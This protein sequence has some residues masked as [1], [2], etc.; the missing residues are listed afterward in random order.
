[1]LV[2]IFGEMVRSIA[3]LKR[4]MRSIFMSPSTYLLVGADRARLAADVGVGRIDDVDF[5]L[6]DA[7]DP[8]RLLVDVRAEPVVEHAITGADRRAAVLAG[9]PRQAEPRREA[10]EIVHVR[11]HFVAQ[12]G[13]ERQVRPQP[14]IV[15]H[16]DRRFEVRDR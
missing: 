7:V 16:V 15:L 9:R 12:P 10:A 4:W 13:T 11:L 5:L 6:A 1:M 8:Q 14:Q 3:A 2:R